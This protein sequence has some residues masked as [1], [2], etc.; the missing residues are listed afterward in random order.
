[1]SVDTSE[2]I[3]NMTA[4]EGNVSGHDCIGGI[5]GVGSGGNYEATNINV[6]GNSYVGGLMRTKIHKL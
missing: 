3:G 1:M 4:T 6:S 5:A 2:N